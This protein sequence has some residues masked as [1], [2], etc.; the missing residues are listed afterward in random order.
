[1]RFLWMLF[2]WGSLGADSYSIVF[3]HIGSQLPSYL[4]VAI[5]QARLFNPNC[6]IYVL[7]NQKAL[8]IFSP[9]VPNVHLVALESLKK[10]SEHK[11]FLKRVKTAPGLF[12]FAMERFFFLDSFVRANHL[13]HVFHLE[14]DV[15]IYA[16]LEKKLPVFEQQY[17]GMLATVFATDRRCVPGFIYIFD[18]APLHELVQFMVTKAHKNDISDMEL[19]SQF[20]DGTYKT[21]SDYL[22]M[23]IPSYEK[24]HVLIDLPGTVYQDGSRY[25]NHVEEFQCIFDGAALGQ[26]FGGLDA[27][28]HPGKARPGFINELN[29][30]NAA[31]FHF[32][33]KKDAEGR[34][35][36]LISY[37][38]ETYL[39]ANLH[40]HGKRLEAFSSLNEEMPALPTF[41]EAYSSIP[42]HWDSFERLRIVNP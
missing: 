32:A 19:I 31:F 27:A 20:K 17:Q 11:T 34:Y 24:D 30:Y 9:P 6:P 18:E 2:V 33:W 15:M 14:N 7:G 28:Y 40:I 36:P 1:M 21:R 26:Y 38:P 35:I 13:K 3:V 5:S 37:G 10:S 12:R 8:H 4:P 29:V 42:I 23:L 41:G 39:I 25:A 16:D 22:P